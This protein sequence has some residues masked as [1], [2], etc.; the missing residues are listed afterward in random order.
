MSTE[1]RSHSKLTEGGIFLIKSQSSFI[2]DRRNITS[3]DNS[4]SI[5]S[6]NRC[7]GATGPAIIGRPWILDLSKAFDT[8][9]HELLIAELN[10]YG[11]SPASLRLLYSYL[12]N[13]WQRTKINNTFS[14][15]SEILLGV[16]QGSI[17]GPLLFNIYL[18]DLF[19]IN[20]DSDLCNFADDNTSHPCDLSLDAP[21]HKLEASAKSVIKWV[22]YNYMKLNESKCKLLISGNKE[23]V[24]IATVGSA[25]IIESHE[26]TLLVVILIGN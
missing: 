12:S 22:D 16:Q 26:V 10:T 1:N 11:F 17:L 8:L 21:V 15:W 6:L 18:N 20:F 4:F 14:F 9:N 5:S 3:G 19:F 25:K 24:I 7:V 2:K 13:R 23:E